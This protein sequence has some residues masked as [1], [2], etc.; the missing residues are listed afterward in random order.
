MNQRQ[1]ALLAAAEIILAVRRLALAS[2]R[3]TA[4]ATVGQITVRPNVTSA[5]AGEVDLVVDVRDVE[6]APRAELVARIEDTI[7][8]ASERQGVACSV[9]VPMSAVPGPTHVH[10]QAAIQATCESLGVPYLRMTSGASHDAQN[11]LRRVP[12]GM[13]FV[14]SHEGRSHSPAEHTDPEQLAVGTDVLIGT[15]LSLATDNKPE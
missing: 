1:D 14:P 13:I 7:R 4:R 6:S 11:V 15:L 2:E 12:A 9:R 10:V 8:D 5:V 3:D